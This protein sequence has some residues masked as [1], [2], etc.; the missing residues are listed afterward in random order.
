MTTDRTGVAIPRPPSDDR[1]PPGP[2]PV[3]PEAASG[4]GQQSRV[5]QVL[6]GTVGLSAGRGLASLISM[7]WLVVAARHLPLDQFGNLAVLL[8][9][10]AVFGTFSDPG[11]QLVL[12]EHTARSRT[13]FWDVLRPV[14]VRRQVAG[15]ICAVLTG[16]LYALAT[17]DPDLVVPLLFSVSL[18]GTAVYGSTL[19]AYRGL[20]R[21]ALDGTNEVGS[22]LFVLAAGTYWLS[23]DG[24]LR[25]AVATYALAD[26]LSA[27]I[28]LPVVAKRFVTT[29]RDP[30][31]VDLRLRATAP[32]ALVFGIQVIYYKV[33][34][35]LV[36]L[37][38][39]PSEAGLYGA[40][41]RL[42]E[43]ALIPATAVS[44]VIVAHTAALSAEVA[45][46]D[47]RRYAAIAVGLTVPL[48]LCGAVVAHTALGTLFGSEFT[49]ATGMTVILLVSALPSAVVSACAPVVGL[50]DR[51]AFGVGGALALALNVAANLVAIPLFG[52]T[53]AAWANVLS[54]LF[55]AWWLLRVLARRPGVRGA[56]A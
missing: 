46:R 8:A 6:R 12:A 22:R 29:A 9:V 27:L 34:I 56:P 17:P 48:S 7:A 50:R 25:A 24:G 21:V 54:Q 49:S 2:G 15:S 31:R 44:S 28:I 5:W 42:L 45:S 20:G 32:L 19:C 14:L 16:V 33:D 23:H 26:L 43:A 47:T 11:L 40:G 51:R 41:Y 1:A 55:L 35:Y 3:A 30:V 4:D 39:G 13:I 53:G 10:G 52:L 36:G 18:L 38:S 37:L